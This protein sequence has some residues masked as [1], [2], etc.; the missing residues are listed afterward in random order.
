MSAPPRN[1]HAGGQAPGGNR[2]VALDAY[3][4]F[5]M[6]AMASAGLG[7]HALRNDPRWGWLAEQFEHRPREGCTFWDLIQPSFLFIVGVAITFSYAARQGQGQ[8]WFGQAGHA[9]KRALLLCVLG[10][11]L[12]GEIQFIRVLQ[13]IALAYL[14]VF[15]FVGLGPW[16]QGIV[17][18]FLLGGHTAA[19]W[20]YADARGIEPFVFGNN[21][22]TH[23]DLWLQQHFHIRP[24]Q[25]N[26]VTFNA[27]SSAGTIMF[28]VLC[29]ELLR[30]SLSPAKKMLVLLGAGALGLTVGWFLAGGNMGVPIS[31]PATVPLVKRLWT[32]SFAVFAAGWTCLMLAAFYLVTDIWQWRGWAFPLVVV[33]MNSI[34]MYMAASLVGGNLRNLISRG[35][36]P[37]FMTESELAAPDTAVLTACLALFVLWLFCY[38]L[39]RQK[40]FFKV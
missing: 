19:Y 27:V 34:A 17:A 37:L 7:M 21:F 32:A 13:Q 30:G 40:F 36:L 28:G 11:V 23:V 5:V 2:L 35:V 24:S 22:G 10:F 1:G 26:Y 38:A 9:C 25:G 31:F 8:S 20:I 6:L 15:P 33:G 16:V 12:D 14:I 18:V 3:R 39:Y 4:G 29:G